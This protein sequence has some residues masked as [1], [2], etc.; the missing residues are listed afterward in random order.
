MTLLKPDI[1]EAFLEFLS[2]RIRW[3]ANDEDPTHIF[4]HAGELEW[5]AWRS[6]RNILGSA[7]SSS[8]AIGESS[9]NLTMSIANLVHTGVITEST[10][11]P[12]RRVTMDGIEGRL[13]RQSKDISDDENDPNASTVPDVDYA[14]PLREFADSTTND[15]D[16][17]H[18]LTEQSEECDQ[19]GLFD[20]DHPSAVLPESTV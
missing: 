15:E 1:Q 13:F 10:Q 7:K 11:R 2:C 19:T 8:L 17:D 5:S 12:A 9:K 16:T 14:T 6:L 4:S 3:R 18:D 20:K